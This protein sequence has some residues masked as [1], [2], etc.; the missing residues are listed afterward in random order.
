MVAEG[1]GGL[2]AAVG[3]TRGG[4]RQGSRRHVAAGGG[5]RRRARQ[6]PKACG[7]EAAAKDTRG[8]GRQ[9]QLEAAGGGVRSGGRRHARWRQAGALEAC[10]GRRRWQEV[11]AVRKKVGMG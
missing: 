10:G 9:G 8:D 2:E 4:G 1:A 5:E 7:L 6:W 11:C 3:G